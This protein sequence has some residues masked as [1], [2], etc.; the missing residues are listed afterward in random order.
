MSDTETDADD[1]P[2]KGT[3]KIPR[4]DFERHNDRRKD[5]RLT[6]AEYINGVAPDGG[7]DADVTEQLDRI[8]SAATTTEERVAELERTLTEVTQR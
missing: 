1:T 2:A 5:L 6:W 3:I 4:D 8:E 7:T